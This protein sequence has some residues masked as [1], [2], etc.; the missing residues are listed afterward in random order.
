MVSKSVTTHLKKN[1]VFYQTCD[2]K[3]FFNKITSVTFDISKDTSC[4]HISLREHIGKTYF[5]QFAARCMISYPQIK[6]LTNC[7]KMRL[8]L[9]VSLL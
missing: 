1:V 4:C 7:E 9:K 2:F 8:V 3:H 5:L 6:N